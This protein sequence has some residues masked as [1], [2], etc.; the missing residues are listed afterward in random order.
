[1]NETLEVSS[2][3]YVGPRTFFA[4][5]RKYFHGRKREIAILKGLVMSR[6][7]VLFSRNLGREN[8]PCCGP[9]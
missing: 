2:N 5:Q 3:P 6:R 1:M 8:H 9:G 4:E 7:T